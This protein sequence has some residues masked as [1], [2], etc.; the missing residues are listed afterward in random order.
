M[1]RMRA[2]SKWSR[3]SGCRHSADDDAS[4]ACNDP[5]QR[6][7]RHAMRITKMR[8]GDQ[9]DFPA[10]SPSYLSEAVSLR[11]L[12]WSDGGSTLAFA[13]DGLVE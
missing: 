4:L 13:Y 6:F 7:A 11:T 12:K 10:A 1:I 3:R 9:H 2:A 5:G 8:I